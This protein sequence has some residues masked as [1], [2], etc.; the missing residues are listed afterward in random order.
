MTRRDAFDRE[1]DP[2]GGP[3]EEKGAT[4]DSRHA[5]RARRDERQGRKR[6]IR[7][8]IAVGAVTL[9]LGAWSA[10]FVQMVSGHDPVLARQAHSASGT[11]SSTT[12]SST[13]AAAGESSSGE[14]SGATSESGSSGALSTGQS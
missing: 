5:A 1:R 12:T 7:R 8:R 14:S 11:S 4:G 13:A 2:V 9:F 10:I 3:P 6:T